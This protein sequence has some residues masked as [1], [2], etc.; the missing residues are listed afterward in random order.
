MKKS[1]LLCLLVLFAITSF[2]Q[3]KAVTETGEE[4]ILY[5][6][7]T[8]KY[9]NDSARLKN[10]ITVN[11]KPFKKSPNSTFLLKSTKTDIGI[12]IDSKKWSFKKASSNEDAEYELD[13]RGKDLYGMIITEKIEI[14]LETLKGLAYDNAK[15]VATDLEIVKQEYRTVNDIKV[16]CMQMN[17]N[18]QGVKFTYYGYYFSNAKGTVQFLTYTAQNL[19]KELLPDAEEL[20]NGLVL[21]K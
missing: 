7:G 5:E 1:I 6:N 16:L 11:P 18:M 20:L 3:K 17:G 9:V 15:A 2:S 13:L 21:L 8:W 14:P 19:L 10:D 4:V 12:W